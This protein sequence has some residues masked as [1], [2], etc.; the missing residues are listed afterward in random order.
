[1]RRTVPAGRLREWPQFLGRRDDLLE[2]ARILR[3]HIDERGQ[4]A[5]GHAIESEFRDFNVRTRQARL[6]RFQRRRDLL[7]G[8][9]KNTHGRNL[10]LQALAF[11][12]KFVAL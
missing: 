2:F 12:R 7:A 5:V 4:G 1:M 3:P 11:D 6:S 8:R 9:R 10:I